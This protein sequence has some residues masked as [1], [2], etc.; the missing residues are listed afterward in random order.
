[1]KLFDLFNYFVGVENC[2]ITGIEFDCNKVDNG[3]VF[4]ALRGSKHD[5]HDF[6]EKAYRNGAIVAVVEQKVEC[7]ILQIVVQNTRI[8]LAKLSKKFYGNACDKVP[9]I[10]ITGTNGKTTTS[11]IL[12]T[13]LG[14]NGYN[15][16]VIGTNGAIFSGK[17]IDCCLT[18][19]D[20]PQLHKIIEDAVNDGATHIIMEAS[21]HA[22]AL[23]KLYGIN[24]SVGAFT[25][26]SQDH[27]DYFG[28]MSTY[29]RAKSKL[30]T[31]SSEF[32]LNADDDKVMAISGEND[33]TFGVGARADMKLS[34]LICCEF[35]STFSLC[36]N[37]EIR[38]VVSSLVGKFNAYNVACA[39]AIATKLGVEFSS[40]CDSV[41]KLKRV[42]GRF[43]IYNLNKRKVVIDFAHTEDGLENLLINARLLTDKKIVLV[44]GCGGNR[45]KSKREKMGIVASKL[46]DLIVL[47]SDN[48][49]YE[50]PIGIITEIENGIKHERFDQY[51]IEIDRKSAIKLAYSLTNEG[52]VLIIAGKGAEKFQEING[53]KYAFSDED[54][55][56]SVVAESEND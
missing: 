50:N 30:K 26:F 25:N 36:Y 22:L 44:F 6:V 17:T 13:I 33:T 47:T 43:N 12:A 20:P 19:P 38:S 21:A 18:T 7:E 10:A 51:Y 41:S 56:M 3:N 8:E 28:N 40:A 14:E 42:D 52:D 1:M 48:P 16:C 54:V 9:V 4:I 53:I 27:L 29:Y 15:P 5:G 35:G 55:L 23:D 2:D 45:D 37:G 24:F 49:R 11:H 39:V 31:A 34:D 46:S 32:V